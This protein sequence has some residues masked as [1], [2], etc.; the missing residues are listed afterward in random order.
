MSAATDLACTASTQAQAAKGILEQLD[1]LG[2]CP[3]DD[4]GAAVWHQEAAQLHAAIN[5]L[6]AKST[7]L[8]AMSA[9]KALE[10]VW[11]TLQQLSALNNQAE[12]AIA[13]IKKLSDVFTTAAAVLDLGTAVAAAVVA[14]N[15]ATVMAAGKAFEGVLS[16]PGFAKKKKPAKGD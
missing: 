9:S 13:G 12:E 11:K 1:G 6:T 16:S 2:P 5:R 4:A 8:Y 7:E 14:P 15:P 10:D 3:I